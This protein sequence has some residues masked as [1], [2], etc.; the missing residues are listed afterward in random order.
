MK[1]REVLRILEDDGPMDEGAKYLIVIEKG[2]GNYSAYSPDIPGCIATGD[3]I[4]ETLENMREAL[5]FHLE[6]ISEEGEP[7]P[8]PRGVQ[9][10]LN[11]VKDSAGEDY[12][13]T[14][15]SVDSVTPRSVV[16]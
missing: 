8:N 11:A 2:E 15:I 16:V 4:E 10:Y 7:L 1:I 9:S 5:I 3:T 12:S 6:T 14:D 13:L